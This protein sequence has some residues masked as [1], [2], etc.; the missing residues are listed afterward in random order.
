[1]LLKTAKKYQYL[2]NQSLT[3]QPEGVLG[4]WGFGVLGFDGLGV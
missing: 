4:F 3:N 2:L 1:M